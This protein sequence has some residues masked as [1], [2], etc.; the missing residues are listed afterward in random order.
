MST[1][2]APNKSSNIELEIAD[3][4]VELDCHHPKLAALIRQ[5]YR[6]FAS[7]RSTAGF[8]A[9]VRWIGKVRQ[10]ALLDVQ[11][12]FTEGVLHY[13]APGY[14]GTIDEKS[15]RG[16]LTLS[17]AQ[18]IEEIDYFLRTVYALLAYA[19]GGV[20]IHAAG[21]VRG[22]R[23][24]LF[25]GH[26]GSGKTTVCQVSQNEHTILNDDL[27]LLLPQDN[28]WRAYGTPFWNPTQVK[29]SSASAPVA[30]MYLLTQADHVFTKILPAG[31]GLASLIANVPVI[32]QDPSRN[33]RILEILSNLQQMVPI[34]ELYFLP[35][36]SFWNAITI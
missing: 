30:A 33:Q 18:P 2:E 9:D 7:S 12:Y 10:N 31:R 28:G 15:S 19:A 8:F 24:Y 4:S 34:F 6:D 27:I 5:R 29:P 22:E 1:S 13:S 25:F 36:N 23:A 11:P 35:D 14:E 26:S 32:T 17:S 20:L 16:N 21:I 3:L